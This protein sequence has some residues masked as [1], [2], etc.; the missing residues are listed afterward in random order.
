MTMTVQ[1]ARSTLEP[2]FAPRV[3]AVVGA[4]RVANARYISQV[5]ATSN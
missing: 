1:S 5:H 3:I 2:F 4:N